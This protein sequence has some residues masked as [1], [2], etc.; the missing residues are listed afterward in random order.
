MM[1]HLRRRRCDRQTA[2]RSRMRRLHRARRRLQREHVGDRASSMLFRKC[3][4]P[5]RQDTLVQSLTEMR[6]PRDVECVK[7]A[8]VHAT[9]IVN[10]HFELTEDAR[11]PTGF[12]PFARRRGVGYYKRSEAG[13]LWRRRLKRTLAITSYNNGVAC[14]GLES[15]WTCV[16]TSPL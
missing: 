8:V 6:D 5:V 10:R 14:P 1:I 16:C 4:A 13:G 15:A 7:R 11:V 2:F 3:V 9:P 12:R